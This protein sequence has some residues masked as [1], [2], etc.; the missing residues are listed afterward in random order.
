MS[1]TVYRHLSLRQTFSEFPSRSAQ[2]LTRVCLEV[3]CTSSS[4]LLCYR[5][6]SLSKTRAGVHI[7]ELQNITRHENSL[8]ISRVTISRLT[9]KQY[10]VKLEGEFAQLFDVSALKIAKC[11]KAYT[12]RTHAAWCATKQTHYPVIYAYS[13]LHSC[14][15]FRRYYLA[16]LG[17]LPTNNVKLMYIL[18][19]DSTVCKA[20]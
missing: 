18:T 15:T 7:L 12:S 19:S 13:L 6:V 20:T 1:A 3:K 2:K 8:N 14:Y 4:L 17:E 10:M 9:D 11:F 16:I 5:S